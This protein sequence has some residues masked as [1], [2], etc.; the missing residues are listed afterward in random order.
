MRLETAHG[1]IVS[2]ERFIN[3]YNEVYSIKS[4]TSLVSNK[5]YASSWFTT[6]IYNLLLS[7]LSLTLIER[8]RATQIRNHTVL[9]KSNNIKIN[10]RNVWLSYI[11]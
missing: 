9:Q 6:Y 10:P 7:V 11:R 5:L 3:E 8:V 4:D 1:G 2:V